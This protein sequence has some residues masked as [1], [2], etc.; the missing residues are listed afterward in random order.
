MVDPSAAP[1]VFPNLTGQK[2]LILGLGGGCD[3][4]T[5]YA[6]SRFLDHGQSREV[7][8]ANTKTGDVGSVEHVTAHILRVSGP[9]IEA[10]RRVRGRGKAWIDHSVPRSAN[11][12]P[13]IVLLGDEVAERALAGELQSLQ[14]DLVIGVDTGGDSIARKGGRGHLGRDQ[15]ILGVL[16]RAGL[17]LLHV[18]VAPGS[19]GEASYEDLRTVIEEGV[20]EGHYRGWFTLDPFL[21]TF[22]LFRESL[23]PT[24]T[25]QIILAAAEGRL[26][27]T[28][29]GRVVVPRGRK[30][31]VPASWL[32]TGFVFARTEAINR[33]RGA[34]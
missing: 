6:L 22:G 2:V 27:H 25:P 15:R 26:A 17:P 32:T 16:R 29:D 33:P 20:A 11:G 14:F 18:V 30:P 12:S 4:I 24:R 13:W 31:A 7:V 19:D 34:S 28:G 23:S 3:I 21:P 5:A 10:G 8:Y 1:F 9:V